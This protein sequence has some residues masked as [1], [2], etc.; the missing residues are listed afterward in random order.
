[1]S[2]LFQVVDPNGITVS[3]T[4]ENWEQHIVK[5]HPEVANCEQEVAI[6]IEKPLAI[7]QDSKH[8]ERQVFYRPSSFPPPLN[9]GF[10]RTVVEYRTSLLGK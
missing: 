10:I 5:H 1:M 9:R 4:G 7:Y 6:S 3:C 8:V 2:K